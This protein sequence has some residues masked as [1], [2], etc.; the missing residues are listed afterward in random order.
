MNT[1]LFGV[2][3]TVLAYYISSNIY[4]R[5]KIVFLNPVLVGAI[6]II[7]FLTATGI[8]HDTYQEGGK[9]VTF[10][11][12]PA[13]ISLAIPL[14][15]K[16]ELLKEHASAILI[17]IF[18][19]VFTA[20]AAVA[21]LGILFKLDSNL[22]ISL[23]PKSVTM[24]IGVEITGSMGGIVQITILSIVITGVT[25][26]IIAPGV[27]KLFGVNDPISQGV[28]IGTASHAVGTSKA[29][30]MGETQGAM[31]GL[32]IGIAGLMTVFIVPILA[33]II[34]GV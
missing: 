22:I 16:R 14:Y 21:G 12:G 19:G 26:A 15:K 11:L 8:S 24:P 28:G 5:T 25:G 20:V 1:P 13:T 7:V 2:F 3:A 6:F 10:L 18:S 31:S 9:L 4:K 34:F 17:G 29:M 30:E 33:K 32:S 27:M 23:L